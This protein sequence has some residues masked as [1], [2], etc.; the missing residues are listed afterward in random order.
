MN[1]L[2]LIGTFL[3]LFA[4]LNA[5]TMQRQFG[6]SGDNIKGMKRLEHYGGLAD[7]GARECGLGLYLAPAARAKLGDIPVIRRKCRV[8]WL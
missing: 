7:S 8:R 1:E 6:K 5:K 3:L 4:V 2:P